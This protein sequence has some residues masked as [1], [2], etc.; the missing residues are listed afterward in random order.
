[1]IKKFLNYCFVPGSIKDLYEDHS[2]S[3]NRLSLFIVS[4]VFFLLETV[5]IIRILFLSSMNMTTTENRFYFYYSCFIFFFSAFYLL[6]NKFSEDKKKLQR[7][8]QYT[9]F[10]FW[11]IWCSVL[12]S[13]HLYLHDQLEPYILIIGFFFLSAFVLLKPIQS[14]LFFIMGCI[15]FIVLN[16]PYMNPERV[17]ILI[18]ITTLAI[19]ISTMKFRQIITILTLQ[20]KIFDTDNLIYKEQE[21]LQLSL[22]K[23]RIIMGQSNDIM[24]EWDIEEDKVTF[25]RNWN[26]LFHNP[27]VI[28]DFQNWILNIHKLS[29][30]G[31][32]SILEAMYQCRTGAAYTE[33]DLCFLYPFS[34]KQEWFQIRI[35]VQFDSCRRPVTGI[36]IIVNIHRQKTELIQLRSMA[37]TD[38]LTGLLNKTAMEAYAQDTLSGISKERLLAMFIL[39]LDN[40]KNVNDTYGHPCGD[41]VLAETARCMKEVF[42]DTKGLGRIGGDEFSIL[43]SDACKR[44]TIEEKALLL[45][46]KISGIRWMEKNIGVSCSIGI[47]IADTPEISYE[48]LYSLADTALYKAKQLGKSRFYLDI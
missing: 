48:M 35:S 17:V 33:C 6:F 38:S 12:S 2:L 23:H 27:T 26:E 19:I 30:Q 10:L 15:L 14:T 47:T 34:G 36:G 8:L 21:K 25:S 22:E 28:P 20:K 42:E 39:D 1:M 31:K 37:Q 9:A 3:A 13:C 29:R 24:F 45:M 41:Y 44:E 32:K 46:Q 40:F 18:V 7:R 16:L 5:N 43:L 4:F 11:L